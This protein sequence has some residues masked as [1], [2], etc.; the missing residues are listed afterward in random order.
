M[1]N[2]TYSQPIVL[3]KIG[4]KYIHYF[5]RQQ[6][7]VMK[8]AYLSEKKTDSPGESALIDFKIED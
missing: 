6:I 5:F 4:G 7:F 3:S 1:N 8:N 2:Q